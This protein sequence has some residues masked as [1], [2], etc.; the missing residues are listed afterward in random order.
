M[1]LGTQQCIQ[2]RLQRKL[3]LCSSTHSWL[4]I[5]LSVC[6]LYLMTHQTPERGCGPPGKLNCVPL[7][8]ES[9][10][11]CH[12]SISFCLAHDRNLPLS[13]WKLISD[14]YCHFSRFPQSLASEVWYTT[15]T[16]LK[17]RQ[18]INVFCHMWTLGW[19]Q[20]ISNRWTKHVLHLFS[21]KGVWLPRHLPRKQKPLY[22]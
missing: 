5:T 3:V 21:S 17:S 14:M 9:L 8:W 11:G 12:K 1:F 15:G 20:F 13:F 2:L 6:N 7:I 4:Q 19:H 18:K 22:S 10:K 16:Y